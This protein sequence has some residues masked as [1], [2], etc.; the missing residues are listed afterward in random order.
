MEPRVTQLDVGALVIQPRGERRVR[1]L[2]ASREHV[3][4]LREDAV[5]Q[6]AAGKFPG[7]FLVGIV[8]DNVTSALPPPLK[9]RKS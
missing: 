7:Y 4:A 5:A 8:R 6:V 2:R 1:L 9:N 3:D